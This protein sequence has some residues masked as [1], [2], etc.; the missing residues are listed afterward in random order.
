MSEKAPDRIAT[1]RAAAERPRTRLYLTIIFL[2]AVAFRLA[3]AQWAAGGL[4]R[5]LAGDEPDYV[6]RALNLAEGQGLTDAYGVASSIRPPGLPILLA[7]FFSLA[8]PNIVW[9]R[10]LMCVLG[11]LLVPVC[12]LLGRAL[13][14]RR[15]G[16]VCALCAMVFPNWVWYSGDLL[17]DL[18]SATSTGLLAWA[19]VGGWRRN[20]LGWFA[21]AG[22]IGGAGVLFRST[23]LALLPGVVLWVFLVLPGWR[24]RFAASVL[25]CVGFACVLAPWTIRNTLVQGEFVLISTQGGPDLYCSNNPRATGILSHD[26]RLFRDEG[27]RIYPRDLFPNEA[28]RSRRYAEDAMAFI[29]ENPGR[30][31]RLSAVRLGELWKLYSPRVPLWQNLL[32]IGSF[33]L[34][35]PFAVLHVARRGW[36]RGAA[37]LFV[38]LIASQS[39]VHIVFWS[40]IRYRMPIEPL[41]LALAAA[42]FAWLFD[43]RKLERIEAD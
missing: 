29:R 37:M 27:T 30:F 43:R 38:I 26:F 14:G 11:A 23:G 35:L 19:L 13:A 6:T 31:L 4:N 7:L 41:V 34:A 12:F 8:G 36:R 5:A 18:L 2:L 10:V 33:G 9:A 22:F 25:A 20:S 3:A 39:A 15:T 1:N 40:V 24:R 42:G 32:T 16:L 21:L 28:R 17:A